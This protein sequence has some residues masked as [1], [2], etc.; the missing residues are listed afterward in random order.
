MSSLAGRSIFLS[1]FLTCLKGYF[2]ACEKKEMSGQS[3]RTSL[4]IYM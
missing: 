3:L 4:S 1:L 2:V